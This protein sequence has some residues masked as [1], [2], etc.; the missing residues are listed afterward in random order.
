MYNDFL[1]TLWPTKGLTDPA[2]IVRE[3]QKR[4]KIVV[5]TAMAGF[6][7]MAPLAIV[8]RK[9]NVILSAILLAAF[10]VLFLGFYLWIYRCPSCGARVQ[11]R[12]RML[13][14]P[15]RCG[16]CGALLDSQ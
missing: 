8:T 16:R 5:V 9:S 14:M 15:I 6:V 4:Q 11:Q 10:A 2:E 1:M 7:L 13:R 3:F 12:R